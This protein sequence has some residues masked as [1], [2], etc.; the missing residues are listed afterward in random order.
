MSQNYLSA[1]KVVGSLNW[2]INYQF[3]E[4]YYAH[5]R[6]SEFRQ[7]PENI[8]PWFCIQ[9]NAYTSISNI[10]C[11]VL[12]LDWQARRKSQSLIKKRTSETLYIRSVS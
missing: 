6:I 1:E 2:F 5:I 4:V 12:S 10:F 9:L 3:L 7:N 11:I 8:L